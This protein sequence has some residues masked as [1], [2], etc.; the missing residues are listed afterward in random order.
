MNK[1]TDI[2]LIDDMEV[3]RN[4]LTSK[5]LALTLRIFAQAIRLNATGMKQGELSDKRLHKEDIIAEY[6]RIAERL[7]NQATGLQVNIKKM[8]EK[9]E[10]VEEEKSDAAAK[11]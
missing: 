1:P 9:G 8:V 2:V 5:G 10:S 7:D 6:E 11:G 4:S 3:I